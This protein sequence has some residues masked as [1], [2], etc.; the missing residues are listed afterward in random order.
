MK[1]IDILTSNNV[2]INYELASVGNR[3]LALILDVL[4]IGVYTLICSLMIEILGLSF[5]AR[6]NMM[7]VFVIPVTTFYNLISEIYLNG[8][9]IGKKALAIKVVKIT[10]EKPSLGDYF[11]R[12]TYRIVDIFLSAGGIAA[13]FVSASEKGQRLG[14]LAANTTVIKLNP[15]NTA[16]LKDILRIA[17]NK[18]YIPTYNNVTQLTDKDMLLIKNTIGRVTKNPNDANKKIIFELIE[19]IKNK[20]GIDVIPKNKIKFLKTLLKDYIVLTR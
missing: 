19:K 20:L 12:W 3:I 11:I 16:N 7:Y 10:G 13:I 17:N 4:I 18:D 6:Q 1:N 8:Q 5:S 15:E 2:T 9:T 14:D